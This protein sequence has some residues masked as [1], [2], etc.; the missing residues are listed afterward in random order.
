MTLVE[1][2]TVSILYVTQKSTRSPFYCLISYIASFL[3]RA[4]VLFVYVSSQISQK[5]TMQAFYSTLQIKPNE[6]SLVLYRYTFSAKVY[7]F[8][9]LSDLI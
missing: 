6:A 7:L 4:Y 8:Y 9:N 3:W 1:I 5:G 2:N